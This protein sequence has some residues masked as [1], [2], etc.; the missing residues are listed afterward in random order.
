MSD[1][2]VR[3]WGND[4]PRVVLVHGSMSNG[5]TTWSEQRPL[6][7]RGHR[8]LVPD[9]RGYG[10][11]PNTAGEDFKVDADDLVDLLGDVANG[12]A[13]LVGHSYGGLAVLLAAARTPEVVAS[14]AVAEP[15]TYRLALDDPDVADL[16]DRHRQ[17]WDAADELSDR[18]FMLRFVR[19]MGGDPE[20]LSP[21]L[22][23]VWERRAAPMRRGRPSWEAEI[24]V[25]ALADAD[26]P[27]L[28]ASGD[29]HP[30][31]EAVCD[32]LAD[33]VG[34]CRVA[35]AGMGHEVQRTGE[36]FNEA[37]L[38]LWRSTGR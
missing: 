31:F 18:E 11:S 8:L 4:G 21:Q 1:L 34:A 32:R 29:H 3:T 6:A 10:R 12:G 25:E 30:A 20:A 24:P 22:L 33:G 5:S 13:H 19:S 26:A 14:V 28:V 23:D 38:T 27:I 2:Y 15:P 17:L 35:I 16:V 7:A 37:L 9:R 36:P